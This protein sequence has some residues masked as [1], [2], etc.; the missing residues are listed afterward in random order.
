M[1]QIVENVNPIFHP[2]VLRQRSQ[3]MAKSAEEVILSSKVVMALE[4]N[5]AKGR[6]LRALSIEGCDSKFFERNR[7]LVTQL[8]TVRYGDKVS[9][10]GLEGFLDALDENDHWLLIAPLDPSLL[11]FKQQRV[12]ASELLEAPL[13]AERILLVEN[14]KCI[15]QLPP[16]P[17]TIAILGAGQNLKWL[18]AIWLKKKCVAYWGDID[19]WG[20]SML[21]TARN[22]L[23]TLAPLMME[24]AVYE[25]YGSQSAVVE[26]ETAG[27]TPP[28][29]LTVDEIELYGYLCDQEKG[30]LEQEFLPVDYVRQRVEHWA[31]G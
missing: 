21:S 9:E 12:R 25:R 7:R 11:P 3:I 24:M 17:S 2:A 26:P 31:I 13:E 14:E 23:P 27:L 22:H 18:S 16:L 4:P 8:L 29:D 28:A 15:Y 1:G 30:R 10:Q 20:L 5:C 19:T 6:P